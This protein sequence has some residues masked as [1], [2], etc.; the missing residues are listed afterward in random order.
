[1]RN[2]EY[3][4]A[5]SQDVKLD[6]ITSS[7]RNA[8]ILRDLRDG[9][10]AWKGAH[11]EIWELDADEDSD[12]DCFDDEINSVGDHERK[13]IVRGD[14]DLGWL[15][16]FMSNEQVKDLTIYTTPECGERVHEMMDGI[17]NNR[18]IERIYIRGIHSDYFMDSLTSIIVNSS[19][20]KTLEVYYSDDVGC[21]L[22]SALVQSRHKSSL[23]HLR[24]VGN[25][26]SNEGLVEIRTALRE[27]PNLECLEITSSMFNTTT[28]SEL[29]EQPEG[30]HLGECLICC[31]PM[32]LDKT[33]Y[34][35]YS[36]CGKLICDGCY[37]ANK[38]REDED[39]L[40]HKCLYCR[41]TLVDL[42]LDHNQR[43]LERVRA[44]DPAAMCVMGS[45][46]YKEGDYDSAFEYWT[47]AAELGDAD[48]HHRLGDSYFDGEVVE[49]D[50]KKAVYHYEKAAVGGHHMA[51][52]NLGAIEEEVNNNTERAVKHYIIAAK[53]GF[54][55][56]MKELWGQYSKGNITKEDLDDT[57]RTH[58]AAV[59]E[60][61]SPQRKEA[62]NYSYN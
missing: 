4:D 19:N 24:L 9:E 53:L 47:K 44:N 1:M 31:L 30:T 13:F 29:F 52:H 26:L 32:P 51:R 62:E 10:T 11:F 38:K 58:H 2:F 59:N 36:C 50:F 33:K 35:F 40:E 22:A 60:M 49:E 7:S 42:D 6:D 45:K 28:S 14:D 43:M 12:D 8:Q 17:K 57:L 27:Y 15:G 54:E 48:A 55:K 25:D 3:Y 18:L 56:S 23:T 37:V 61:K 21:S 20:L 46:R 16:Y 41:E 39:G 5:R 34:S